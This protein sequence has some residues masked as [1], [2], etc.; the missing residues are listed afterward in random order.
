[1]NFD[2]THVNFRVHWVERMYLVCEHDGRDIHS[3]F[4][5]PFVLSPNQNTCSHPIL[6]QRRRHTA[7][8]TPDAFSCSI[9]WHIKT[10]QRWRLQS[11]TTA[12][13]ITIT[14]A[15]RRLQHAIKTVKAAGR[16]WTVC[17]HWKSHLIISD[18]LILFTKRQEHSKFS[19]SSSSPPPSSTEWRSVLFAVAAV[20][21]QRNNDRIIETLAIHQTL[22]KV[23]WK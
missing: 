14:A 15:G 4:L 1:M 22:S 8:E 5:V 3:W 10:L 18:K 19:T 12:L 17:R 6:V 16:L 13:T 11:T 21:I 7:P 23:E 20:Q 9:G 2:W